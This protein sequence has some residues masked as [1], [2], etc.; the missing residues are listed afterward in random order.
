MFEHETIRSRFR[1][2][3]LEPVTHKYVLRW[4]CPACGCAIE[5]LV[6]PNTITPLMCPARYCHQGF[7]IKVDQVFVAEPL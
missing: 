6:H 2:R 5:H 1:F 3:K 7:Q 4:L